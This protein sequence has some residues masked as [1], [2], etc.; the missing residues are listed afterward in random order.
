MVQDVNYSIY[1]SIKD[2]GRIIYKVP[3]HSATFN[4]LGFNR[5]TYSITLRDNIKDDLE[6]KIY[7]YYY[8]KD[9]VGHYLGDSWIFNRLGTPI[10]PWIAK[11]KSGQIIE[12]PSLPKFDFE[13]AHGISL[14]HYDD[15]L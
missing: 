10:G 8:D 1:E 15:N 2:T 3:V 14:F 9:A 13:K 6:S 5:A 7:N 4:A 12:M 11:D